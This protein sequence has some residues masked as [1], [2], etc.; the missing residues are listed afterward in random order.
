MDRTQELGHTP[1]GKLLWKYFLPAIIGVLANTLYNIVDRI[2]I[3]RGVGALALSGLSVTFPIMIIA[4]AFGMLVGMG[5]ASLVSIRLGQQNKPEAEKI[6]GNAFTLLIVISFGITVLGLV[7]RD[8][9]LSLFGAG[10][11][12]LGYAKQYI[13]IILWGNIFQGLGF[14]MNNMIRAEGHAKTAM[15]TMLIGAVANA[16]LDPL[17]IFVFKMGVAGAAIATVISMAITSAWVLL[18]F[19][20]NKSGLRLKTANLRL[21]KKIV[22][23]IFSIGMAPFAMQLAGSVINALFNI[24]LIR[25]GGDLAVGAMGIINSVAMMVVFCVIAINMASQPIIGFNYG[26]K[27]YHRVKRTLKLALIAATGI[28]VSGWLAVEIFPGAIISLFNTSDPGLLAIGVRGMRILLFM[29]PVV[30]FQVVGSNF[31]QAIGKARISMF[32]NLLRQV[33]VLIPMVL[34]L[35]PLLKIDGVWL[36]GPLADLIAASITAVMILR[37]VKKLNRKSGA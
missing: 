7:F 5:S 4:M 25:Y 16:L 8:T 18:H 17:F 10:P 36:S 34:I 35:P 20:G 9:I 12:T 11:D 14:G 27:Q 26:A 22:L 24:Q 37:E 21:E 31:F 3:G 30:G 15:Y 32:L 6:L 23:G 29:F 19:T 33:I 2:Y 13:T 1:V 28:T